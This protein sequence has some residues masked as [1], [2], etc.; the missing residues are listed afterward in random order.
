MNE[1][2]LNMSIRKF[3]K[4][5]GINSQQEIERSVKDLLSKGKLNGDEILDLTA[6]FTLEGSDVSWTVKG[7]I[8][9]DD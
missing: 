1:E 3:L 2:I 4:K 6:N 9:L 5:V 7:T 8:K